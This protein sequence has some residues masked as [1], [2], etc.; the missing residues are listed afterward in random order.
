MIK[1]PTKGIV[2]CGIAGFC[3]FEINYTQAT[4]FYTKILTDMHDRLSHRGND[5]FENY[6]KENV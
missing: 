2:M 6:L 4:P 1:I 3:N 5:R